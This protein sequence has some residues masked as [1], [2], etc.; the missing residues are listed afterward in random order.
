MARIIGLKMKTTINGL[1]FSI[2]KD[3]RCY[4][5]EKG[6]NGMVTHFDIFEEMDNMSRAYGWSVLGYC[7]F[8]SN[9]LNKLFIFVSDAT[10]NWK[11]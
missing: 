10:E 6:I 5:T 11:D 7:A 3:A 2:G 1:T 4:V 9:E 8:Q